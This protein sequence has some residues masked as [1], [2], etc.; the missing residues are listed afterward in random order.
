MCFRFFTTGSP[1][2]FM[3]FGITSYT[4]KIYNCAMPGVTDTLPLPY[5][6]GNLKLTFK[7]IHFQPHICLTLRFSRTKVSLGDLP[8]SCH[9]IVPFSFRLSV[10]QVVSC[11]IL[12]GS[13][14]STSI[15]T[16]AGRTCSSI[17]IRFMS[18]ILPLTIFTA[19]NWSSGCTCM[20]TSR[21][22]SISRNSAS[23]LSVSSGAS[24]CR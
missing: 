6:K 5:R 13:T 8:L 7:K 22:W 11:V 18:V 23:I 4:N 2:C 10:R 12:Q 20:F 19:F 14:K 24:I 15:H 1:A 9:A 21:F 17:F 16:L 3:A